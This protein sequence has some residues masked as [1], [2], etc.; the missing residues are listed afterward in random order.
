MDGRY[1]AMCLCSALL[2]AAAASASP[3]DRKVLIEQCRQV[4]LQTVTD[5]AVTDARRLVERLGD[6]GRWPDIDY[7]DTSNAGWKP[8]RHVWRIHEMSSAWAAPGPRQHD[9]VL[10]AAVERAL[11]FWL[12]QDLRSRNWWQN[13]IGAPQA[14]VWSL[15]LIGDALPEHLRQAAIERL[16]RPLTHPRGGGFTGANL[17]W[18]AEIEMLLGALTGDDRAIAAT[19]ERVAR[20]ITI[21]EAEGV[22][23]DWSFHQHGPRL[24]SGQYGSTFTSVGTRLAWI[25]R[26]TPWALPKENIDVLVGHVLN[27]QQWFVHGGRWNPSVLDR[28]A[29]RRDGFRTRS[30]T[31]AARQLADIDAGRRES[32]LAAADHVAG[33]P[34][35]AGPVGTRHYWRSDFTMHRLPTWQVSLHRTS[36]RTRP[37]E[38]GLNDEHLLGSLFSDCVMFIFRRGDEYEGLFPVLDYL[39]LPG[40]TTPLD[41]ALP[42]RRKPTTGANDHF[43][44]GACDGSRAVIAVTATDGLVPSRR[45]WIF[46]P[47]GVICLGSGIQSDAPEEVITTLNQCRLQGPVSVVTTEGTD[48]VQ[49]PATRDGVVAIVHDGLAFAFFEPMRV[50]ISPAVQ[51]GSWKRINNQYDDKP[52]EAPVFIAWI[53][54]GVRPADGHYAYAMIPTDDAANPPRLGDRFTVLSN[55]P[56]VQAVSDQVEKTTYAAFHEAGSLALASGINLAVSDPCTVIVRNTG[57]PSLTVTVADPTQRLERLT[58]TIGDQTFD[59]TLPTG[60]AA[61]SSVTIQR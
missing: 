22:Q 30:L 47:A 46:A 48:V 36:T 2:F 35:A 15:V 58:I 55:I 50:S 5:A 54:H 10:L 57:E 31:V 26:G 9:P 32:L 11:A 45:A 42:A 21:T 38:V 23:I 19:A 40:V 16:Q 39:R 61:G 56:A 7:T 4:L 60:P 59:V 12:S 41:P 29:S 43:V 13:D 1:L 6:D 49:E 3:Q 24:Q 8:A 18:R 17:M 37:V 25:L 28:A 20:E 52:V 53:S 34:G 51:R 14:L 33:K 27:G 44:G